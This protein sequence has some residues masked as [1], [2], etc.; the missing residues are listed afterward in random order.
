MEPVI[1]QDRAGP[2][3]DRGPDTGSSV[4]GDPTRCTRREQQ[5]LVADRHRVMAD[6]I[7]PNRPAQPA[8]ITSGNYVHRDA[9]LQEPGGECQRDRRL[10]GAAGDEIADTH[11]R[12]RRAVGTRD[13]TT[14]MPGDIA[15]HSDGRQQIGEE[16]RGLTPES[17]GGSH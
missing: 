4:A 14:Q 12:D 6:G 10:A 5:R 9:A 8:A 1:E 11:H 15:G 2:G 7:D 13:N 3:R 16:P 17:G